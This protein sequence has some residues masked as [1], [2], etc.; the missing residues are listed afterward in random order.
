MIEYTC[1][2]C[3]YNTSTLWNY[4]TH[5]QRKRLCPAKVR[6]LTHNELM[7]DYTENILNRKYVCEYCKTQFDTSKSKYQHKLRCKNKT[8]EQQI[9]LLA[10]EIEK[11]KENLEHYKRSDVNN[12]NTIVN[13][14]VN[15]G[16]V[17]NNITINVNDFGQERLDHLPKEFLTSCF[18]AQ[19]LPGLIENIYFDEDCPENHNVKLKSSKRELCCIHKD[20][21]WVIRPLN[22]VI[23]Q[24]MNKGVT[25]LKTHYK[26]YPEDIEADM[27]DDELN[28]V[29]EWLNEVLDK[30]RNNGN[31][32]IREI[33]KQILAL[34]ESARMNG[35]NS[36]AIS[37]T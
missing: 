28:E 4:K 23:D 10:N 26:K 3:G 30:R 1:P 27:S 12:T 33:R 14:N 6:D 25:T 37:N 29:K 32:T 5:L 11:I 7:D 9:S 2:R 20:N 8:E 19:D 35:S 31:A 34:M 22:G 15:N 17:N 24:M 16:T 21:T 13:G 18:I 36:N